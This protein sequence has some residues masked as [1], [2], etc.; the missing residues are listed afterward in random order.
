[1]KTL[2][3]SLTVFLSTSL[4]SLQQVEASGCS[5]VRVGWDN[6]PPYQFVDGSTGAITGLDIELVQALMRE[7]GCDVRL[8][9][10]SWDWQLKRLQKKRLDIALA[11]SITPEREAFGKFSN[12]FR[13]EVMHLYVRKEDLS[14]FNFKTLSD[15]QGKDFRLGVLKDFYYG[16]LYEELKSKPAFG[17]NLVEVST[18]K[19]NFLKLEARSVDGIL[20]DKYVAYDFL[21]SNGLLDKVAIHPMYVNE[22]PTYIIVRNNISD[23]WMNNLNNALKRIR[24]KG[25]YSKIIAR[26]SGE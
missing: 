11:A 26:Y 14:K 3:F 6:W 18:D 20:A 12:L 25:I 5:K 7:M 17:N 19:S 15:I 22:S 9:E 8:R 1:M 4:I 16:E 24:E 10:M 13:S 23:D 21:K 2:V